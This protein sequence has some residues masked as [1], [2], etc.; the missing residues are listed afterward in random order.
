MATKSERDYTFESLNTARDKALHIADYQLESDRYIIFSDVH[1]GDRETGSDDFQ[2]NEMIYCYALQY[3]LDHDYRL[4]LNGDI[5]EG[6][7]AE[8]TP[9]QQKHFADKIDA[10]KQASGR[11]G[12]KPA[13]TTDA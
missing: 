11:K 8:M 12:R 3:Y 1:K 13:E 5:E 2:R 6:W 9:D 4:I 10:D 7:E